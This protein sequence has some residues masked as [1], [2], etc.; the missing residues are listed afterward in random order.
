MPSSSH[1][2]H[3]A[4]ALETAQTAIISDPFSSDRQL[5]QQLDISETTIAKARRSL[6][7]AVS[8]ELARTLATNHLHALQFTIND[9]RT[10]RSALEQQIQSL[11]Q[12]LD[13]NTCYYP[14][15]QDTGPMTQRDR[16]ATHSLIASLRRQITELDQQYIHALLDR[17]AHLVL[18][19]FQGGTV[20]LAEPTTAEE[21]ALPS[22]SD[23]VPTSP[24]QEDEDADDGLFARES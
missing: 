20:S 22:S 15:I 18:D 4:T 5:S 16:L 12:N 24:S 19:A 23:Q 8:T 17:Q 3:T 6:K 14:S 10:Q 21:P 9:T 1:A 11:Q 13:D 7:Q 2:R